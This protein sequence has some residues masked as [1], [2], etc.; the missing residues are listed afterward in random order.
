[1]TGLVDGDR[2]Y[3]APAAVLVGAGIAVTRPKLPGP[4]IGAANGDLEGGRRVSV[5]GRHGHLYEEARGLM[6]M[7][8]ER[9]DAGGWSAPSM[10]PT[11]GLAS[12]IR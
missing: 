4:A 1:V 2:Q 5:R 3:R 9:L 7:V 6:A 12:V 8:A 10:T 11:S